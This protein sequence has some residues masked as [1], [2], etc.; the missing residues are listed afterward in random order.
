MINTVLSQDFL[1][2]INL[3][4][5][6]IQFSVELKAVVLHVF[7]A[8]KEH[9]PMLSIPMKLFVPLRVV[10]FWANHVGS[11]L[12][13]VGTAT[14]TANGDLKGLDQSVFGGRTIEPTA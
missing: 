10:T 8:L 6:V 3:S 9:Q 12:Q 5:L 11:M 13:I 7:A 1:Q 14:C 2:P 4:I